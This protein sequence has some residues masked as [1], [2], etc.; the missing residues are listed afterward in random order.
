VSAAARLRPLAALRAALGFVPRAWVRVP[1]ALLLAGASLMLPILVPEAASL[2]GA[3]PLALV[4][5]VLALIAAFGAL[6]RLW[7]ALPAGLL[8]L[9]A[10]RPEL[11]LLGAF[12]QTGI[13][14]ALMFTV[15]A[16]MVFGVFGATGLDLEALAATPVAAGPGAMGVEGWKLALAAALALAAVV[17]FVVLLARLALSG[18]ATV[19][20]GRMIGLDVMRFARGQ[21]LRLAAGLVLAS[22]PL[23][24]LMLW[25]VVG[26]AGQSR[27]L[28]GLFD[29]GLWAAVFAGVQVPLWAGYLAGCWSRLDEASPPPS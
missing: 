15:L 12:V 22:A 10:G 21:G 5:Q 8:G 20:G 26:A 29:Y 2:P 16:L 23:L 25:Q 6:Y 3:A 18:P 19:Q 27:W 1:L 11:R 24:G 7:F 17:V 9:V 4:V 14:L 28:G 13:F